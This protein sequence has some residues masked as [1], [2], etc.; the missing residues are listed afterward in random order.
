MSITQIEKDQ[1]KNK[2]Q[3]MLDKLVEKKFK[4]K[5]Q[6]LSYRDGVTDAIIRRCDSLFFSQKVDKHR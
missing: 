3:F 5:G 4:G 6:Y 2:I 1:L